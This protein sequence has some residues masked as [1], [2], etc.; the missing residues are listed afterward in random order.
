M[1]FFPY[2][3]QQIFYEIH[4][5][6]IPVLLLHGN[7][8]SGQ[9]FA[10]VIP[11]LSEKYQI[12]TMDFLGYGRSDRPTVQPADLWF[13]WA[14]QVQ[15]LCGHLHI[16]K[17][18]LI[19]S[20]GGA[21]A[22]INTALEYPALV[23]A[24]IADSFEGIA[25]DLTITAEIQHGREAAK[26]NE[27]FRAYLQSIHGND[28]ETVF[29]ADTDAVI[30]HAKQIGTFFH[31]P[32]S[33]LRVKLLLTGSAEDEMFPAGHYDRLFDEISRL[34]PFAQS[35]IFAHGSHPAMCSNPQEFAALCDDF[36]A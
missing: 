15:A 1:P 11:L 17:I 2:H 33:E 23:R 26:Q 32:L 3:E 34:T 21:L 36:F 30:R 12:I 27:F 18:N 9:M 5:S 7:T 31:Q 25:A 13:E 35:H 6:G 29:D 19:G 14:K 22:A 16:S 24:L 20:S 10:P 8:A 4:G 28:W